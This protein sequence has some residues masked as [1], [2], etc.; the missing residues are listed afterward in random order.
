MYQVV[1][2]KYFKWKHLKRQITYH[3]S[4]DQHTAFILETMY[5]QNFVS[6]LPSLL[7]YWTP[8]PI[9]HTRVVP[10][11]DQVDMNPI[12]DYE[13]GLRT[14]FCHGYNCWSLHMT[15]CRANSNLSEKERVWCK[16]IA[17]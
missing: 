5:L 13:I 1:A 6:Q 9:N 16:S 4:T 10:G 7:S 12:Q 17:E 8:I 14:L 15:T 3:Y 11:T 2:K